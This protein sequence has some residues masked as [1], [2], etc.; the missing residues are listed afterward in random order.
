MMNSQFLINAVIH[1]DD[2]DIIEWALGNDWNFIMSPQGILMI[3]KSGLHLC[4]A[5]EPRLTDMGRAFISREMQKDPAT[6]RQAPN[7][8][9]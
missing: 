1:K 7:D 9:P 2:M 3:T 5:V 6:E 8:T 4:F